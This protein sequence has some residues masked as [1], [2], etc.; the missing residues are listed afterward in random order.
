MS[1][2]D[3]ERNQRCGIINTVEQNQGGD[4]PVLAV[5]TA[6]TGLIGAS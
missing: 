4:T 5:V 2:A 1:H 6:A 3:T